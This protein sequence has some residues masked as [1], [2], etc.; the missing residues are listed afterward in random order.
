MKTAISNS[1]LQKNETIANFSV[2]WGSL[3]LIFLSHEFILVTE[4]TVLI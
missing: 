4:Y 3:Y 1:F 2:Q